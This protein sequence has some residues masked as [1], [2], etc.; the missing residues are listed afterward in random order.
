MRRE[1]TADA[2]WSPKATGA[3]RGCAR[4][5]VQPPSGKAVDE[6]VLDFQSRCKRPPA[7]AAAPRRLSK[8]PR[9]AVGWTSHDGAI[10]SAGNGDTVTGLLEEP[11]MRKAK[12]MRGRNPEEA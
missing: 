8:K 1:S 4:L 7:R 10:G 2:S 5:L 11:T 12:S 3:R 6:F 9:K